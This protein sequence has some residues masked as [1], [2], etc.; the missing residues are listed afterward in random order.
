MEKVKKK[1]PFAY[2]DHPKLQQRIDSFND[3]IE[4]EYKGQRGITNAV[5]IR[6]HIIGLLIPN[7]ELDVKRGNFTIAEQIVRKYLSWKPNDA[8]AYFLLGEIFRENG[9]PEGQQEA[10]ENYRKAVG[11]DPNYPEPYRAMGIMAYK[12]G[13]KLEARKNLERY[14][15][16][17]PDAEEK[18]YI[19]Q[20]LSACR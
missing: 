12:K 16:L 19:R 11:L 3:L 4:G 13:D 15:A 5:S 20:Y 7:A 2:S 8:K 1:A 14:L 17:Q 6:R 10:L 18:D 9:L